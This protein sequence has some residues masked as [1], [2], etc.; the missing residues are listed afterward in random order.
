M[1]NLSEFFSSKNLILKPGKNCPNKN[2]QT[3]FFKQKHSNTSYEY[4]KFQKKNI[5]L[6]AKDN[7][8]SQP[9][10]Y[11][12]GLITI[13]E[14]FLDILGFKLDSKLGIYDLYLAPYNIK[15]RFKT[16]IHNFINDKYQKISKFFNNEEFSYKSLF[17]LNYKRFEKRYPAE[18]DYM[19]ESYIYP[20]EKELIE[21]KFRNYTLKNKNDIWLVKPVSG[22]C[23]LNISILTNFSDI[24]LKDY[25]ITKYLFNPHLIKGYKYD[26]RFH[27]LISTIKPLK[28]YLYNEGLVRLAS[29]KHDISSCFSKKIF[30]FLT[31]LHINKE[32]KK[33]FIYP[34]NITNLEDSNLWNLETFKKYCFRN[35]INYNNIFNEVSD[36]FIKSII[37]VKEKLT[38]YIEKNDFEITNFYH[39]IGFD[40]IL[41]ENYK[42]YLLELNRHC[43]FRND[44]D[45]EKYFTFN[46]IVDTLNIIGIRPKKTNNTKKLINKKDILKISLEESLCELDRPRGGYE[47][48]FPIKKK[49]EKYKKFFGKNIPE[50]DLEL[51]NNLFE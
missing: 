40:V 15:K 37:S 25:I 45:A 42:P 47:L 13:R 51:W 1:D 44:N 34:Q 39:L 16:K 31:N 9:T 32:N 33:R 5:F 48:I 17:Y 43:G 49:V 22:K 28:L 35:N 18:Y 11:Y 21:K 46:I 38:K 8:K 19:L 24:H 50:E 27:G 6:K 12:Y 14:L 36:I 20:K 7:S 30:S 26:L 23:G 29:E 10:A 2:I 41:D 3:F 4:N